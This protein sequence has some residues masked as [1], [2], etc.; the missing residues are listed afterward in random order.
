MKARVTV[1]ERVAELVRQHGSYQAAGDAIGMDRTHLWKIA[2]NRKGA[3]KVVLKTLGL[4]PG[5]A[6]YCLLTSGP[7]RAT[8]AGREGAR[9]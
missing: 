2:N 5:S 9:R 7:E 3:G 4:D 6:S 8:T 1:A